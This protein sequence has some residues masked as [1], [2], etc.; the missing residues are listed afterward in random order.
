MGAPAGREKG[1]RNALKRRAGVDIPGLRGKNTQ[2]DAGALA[3][4]ELVDAINIRLTGTGA[5]SRSGFAKSNSGG[6]LNG[7]VYGIYDD[8]SGMAPSGTNLTS[9]SRV[10]PQ[11]Y[12]VNWSEDLYAYDPIS[13][14]VDMGALGGPVAGAIV[15]GGKLYVNALVA[16]GLS[17]TEVSTLEPAALGFSPL[18]K[19]SIITVATDS[20]G[21]T[22]M[23]SL[24]GSLYMVKTVVVSGTS[25]VRVSIWDGIKI[26]NE[27]VTTPY[28]TV[29]G[30]LIAT[31][32]EDVFV[33][34]NDAGNVIKQRAGGTW[35][36]LAFPGTVTNFSAI[37]YA[38]YKDKLYVGGTGTVGA[39]TRGVILSWDGTTLAMAHDLGA[40]SNPILAMTTFNGNLLFTHDHK[41]GKYDG[42][43]WTDSE[44]DFAATSSTFLPIAPIEYLG[45][46]YILDGFTSNAGNLYRTTSK[47]TSGSYTFVATIRTTQQGASIVVFNQ[48]AVL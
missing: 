45:E 14:V 6:A 24:Q 37:C 17:T 41:L 28:S 36:T 10:P 8:G 21:I 29:Y 9:G 18:L 22:S 4:E 2:K 46:L 44:K 26:S 3:P 15:H 1:D 39:T 32:R 13:G 25:S 23:C 42:T 11:L 30:N 19:K 34:F 47:S 48:V 27:T 12:L 7:N 33:L 31:Y 16:S 5:K 35:S 20:E 38:V 40:T 43:T